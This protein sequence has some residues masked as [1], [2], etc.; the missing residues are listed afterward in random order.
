M[1]PRNF[2][3]QTKMCGDQA[4]DMGGRKKDMGRERLLRP[5]PGAL[6][7]VETKTQGSKKALH[8]S[9]PTAPLNR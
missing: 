5:G 8:P 2:R 6:P 7:G 3:D 1:Q 4:A 9:S